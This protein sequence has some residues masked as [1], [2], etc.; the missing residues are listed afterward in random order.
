M[1]AS[2]EL[3]YNLAQIT[4]KF[5]QRLPEALRIVDNKQSPYMVFMKDTRGLLGYS[6]D[7]VLPTDGKIPLLDI[8]PGVQFNK[9]Y[10]GLGHTYGTEAIAFDKR[11]TNQLA[12]LPEDSANIGP[13]ANL[14]AR[15]T[16]DALVMSQKTANE[17]TTKVLTS[18]IVAQ[19]DAVNVE[20]VETTMLTGDYVYRDINTKIDLLVAN[21]YMPEELAIVA[22][23]NAIQA[24]NNGRDMRMQLASNV[25]GK[26]MLTAKGVRMYPG[27]AN[28][29]KSAYEWVASSEDATK[30]VFEPTAEAKQVWYVIAPIEAIYW[31]IAE[32]HT[33]IEDIPN[34]PGISGNFMERIGSLVRKER[35]EYVLV[36]T[37]SVTAEE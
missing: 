13:G 18:N 15:I 23:P 8:K 12:L 28:W 7:Y 19:V 29:M 14:T 34:S 20:A 6:A 30:N 1:A 22:I 35:K 36:V 10:A 5:N 24:Y 17:F 25:D 16:K 26:T 33:E 2:I 4:D 9:Q 31:D 21:G 3:N 37:E 32:A 27:K 11:I